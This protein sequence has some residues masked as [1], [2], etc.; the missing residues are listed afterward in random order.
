MIF[1]VARRGPRTLGAMTRAVNLA[2]LAAL[3]A[4]GGAQRISTTTGEVTALRDAW[5]RAFNSRQLD[6]VI[7]TFALDAVVLPITGGRIVSA[8]AI[9][10]LYERI[11]NRL[12][13]HVELTSHVVERSGELAYDS[14]EYVE[15]LTAGASTVNIAGNYVFVFRHRPEGWRIIE[16]IWTEASGAPETGRRP[17]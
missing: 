9:K 5:T 4:C 14:G 16:Q 3:A 11:W 2:T 15:N 17:P 13:P 7:A 10:N 1:A 12:T 6:P 8:A